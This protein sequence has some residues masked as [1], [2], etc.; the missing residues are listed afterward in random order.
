M[1][2]TSHPEWS[3]EMWGRCRA[4]LLSSPAVGGVRTGALHVPPGSVIGLRTDGLTLVGD[5]G[6]P[7]DGAPGRFRL[8]GRARGVFGWPQTEAEL[9]AL[10]RVAEGALET[11]EMQ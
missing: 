8:V 11:G 9:S 5:P 4:R 2:R 3:A 10:K 1:E 6:W 7:D